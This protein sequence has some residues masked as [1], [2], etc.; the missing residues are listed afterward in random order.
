MS[1]FR[2]SDFGLLSGFG[3]R[4]SDFNRPSAAHT[5]SR[6]NPSRNKHQY[7]PSVHPGET[8]PGIGQGWISSFLRE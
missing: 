2:S 7:P 1:F 6:K 4:V 3:L 8:W 5:E